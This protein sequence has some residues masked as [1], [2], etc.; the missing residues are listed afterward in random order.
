MNNALGKLFRI[1]RGIVLAVPRKGVIEQRRQALGVAHA[2]GDLALNGDGL[3]IRRRFLE[4]ERR[5]GARHRHCHQRRGGRIIKE[6][7]PQSFA[8]DLP[9]AVLQKVDGGLDLDELDAEHN[10]PFVLWWFWKL[11]TSHTSKLNPRFLSLSYLS[12]LKR[13]NCAGR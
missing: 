10:L 4:N 3:K 9:V 12:A 7:E 5:V 8:D 6:G 2:I 13:N 1:F 11:K